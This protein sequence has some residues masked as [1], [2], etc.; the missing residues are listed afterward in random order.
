M[1]SHKHF[2]NIYSTKVAIDANQY[3]H[4]AHQ[5]VVVL[6]WQVPNLH[7][8]AYLITYSQGEFYFE[9]WS[10]D[11]DQADDAVANWMR[12]FNQKDLKLI[13]QN[14][15]DHKGWELFEYD[16]K[17]WKKNEFYFE[18]NKLESQIE[19]LV[20]PMIGKLSDYYYDSHQ[21]RTKS[22]LKL[23]ATTTNLG[24]E[25]D[26]FLK[27]KTPITTMVDFNNCYNGLERQMLKLAAYIQF[28]RIWQMILKKWLAETKGESYEKYCQD[29]FKNSKFALSDHYFD[30]VKLDWYYKDRHINSYYHHFHYVFDFERKVYPISHQIPKHLEAKYWFWQIEGDLIAFMLHLDHEAQ[31][32]HQYK[33]SKKLVLN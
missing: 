26:T 2:N 17:G 11:L 29:I 24:K 13:D 31:N 1:N 5:A 23:I 32:K 25:I 9:A 12:Q 21:D 30:Q 10:D 7:E 3:P 15:Y 6:K 22:N 19:K 8:S 33:E 14:H 16:N 20:W 4:L 27:L 28:E 18:K